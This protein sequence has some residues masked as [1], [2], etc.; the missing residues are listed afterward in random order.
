[1]TKLLIICV[2]LL[3]VE[4]LSERNQTDFIHQFI[5]NIDSNDK[6]LIIDTDK[7]QVNPVNNEEK[8]RINLKLA[9][10]ESNF[11]NNNLIQD[12]SSGL[13]TD[14]QPWSFYNGFSVDTNL[15]IGKKTPIGQRRILNLGDIIKPSY[16]PRRKRRQASNASNSWRYNVKIPKTP[17]NPYIPQRFV[18]WTPSPPNS[19]SSSRSDNFQNLGQPLERVKY[20]K[21]H[22]QKLPSRPKPI[23]YHPH[24]RAHP[25]TYPRAHPTLPPHPRCR[26]NCAGPGPPCCA[27]H[28]WRTFPPYV[29]ANLIENW[30]DPL[31]QLPDRILSTITDPAK[32][33]VLL[34]LGLAVFGITFEIFNTEGN[35][36]SRQSPLDD[37]VILIALDGEAWLNK[38]DLY[39]RQREK[40][41]DVDHFS[42]CLVPGEGEKEGVMKCLPRRKKQAA[43]LKCGTKIMYDIRFNKKLEPKTYMDNSVFTNKV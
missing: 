12:S 13:E 19:F 1:M 25:P 8:G 24:P 22:I 11:L 34:L 32:V 2:L 18:P 23:R 38:L 3:A 26:V 7:K 10:K 37:H 30:T 31:L 33:P 27:P 36:T 16:G 21:A 9:S 43:K 4:G 39:V 40:L 17:N 20:T 14:L 41:K 42:C 5:E 6:D 28:P 29:Q 35:P 15:L